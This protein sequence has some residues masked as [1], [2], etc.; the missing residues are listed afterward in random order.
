M[1]GAFG[2]VFL[3]LAESIGAARSFAVRHG[4]DIDPDQELIALGAANAGAGLFGG[5]SVDASFSQSATGEAAGNRTQL[6]SLITAGLILATAI[7][8]A[9]IFANL[10]LSVLAAIVI[11][12]VLSLVNLAELRRYWAWKRTDFLLAM[13][14]LG[15]VVFTTALTGM[16]IAVALS[17]MAIL[18]QASRPYIA[19]LGRI[20]GDPPV[21]ADA[22]RHPAAAPVAGFLMLRPNVP[23]TFVNADVAKDQV[24]AQVRG[25]ADRPGRA[26][27][28]HR[29]D[30]RS[31]R[32]H[33]RHAGGAALRPR[34][35][36][37][38]SC[39]CRRS[40]A[41]SATG[42]GGPG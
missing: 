28:R 13:T 18:Y 33:D 11:A 39:A 37:A 35:R 27:P 26:R 1:T 21:F 23:L 10:P 36:P 17:L 41:R 4:Y 29:R 15:G 40:A 20:P 16:A 31:R 12:S 38:S 9:P 5:F 14:A 34:T 42:C 19:V 22:D 3:A 8:L 6:S 2:I 30:R 32:G 7:V 24:M 25:A